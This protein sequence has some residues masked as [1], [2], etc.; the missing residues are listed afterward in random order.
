[1]PYVKFYN[2]F[3]KILVLLKRDP[4]LYGLHSPKLG[5]MVD[6]V[7]SG[8]HLKDV[9]DQSG[10][11]AGSGEAERYSQKSLEWNAE[12]YLLLPCRLVLLVPV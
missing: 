7:K 8:T 9:E 2:K 5:S 6:L 3:K 10:F 12:L 1:M 4:A 11:A